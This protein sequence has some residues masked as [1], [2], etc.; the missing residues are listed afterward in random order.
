MRSVIVS[1]LV[2][3]LMGCATPKKPKPQ[4]TKVVNVNKDLDSV[5][6]SEF[7]H[8]ERAPIADLYEALTEQTA[9][10]LSFLESKQWYAKDGAG[11]FY[12]KGNALLTLYGQAQSSDMLS[13]LTENEQK[14][15]STA[16]EGHGLHCTS[17]LNPKEALEAYNAAINLC[18]TQRLYGRR[19]G[20]QRMLKD[21][22][23]YLVD[24]SAAD[25]TWHS[26]LPLHDD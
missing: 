6:A 7:A 5:L 11:V 25:D 17:M 2:L 21:K 23:G 19:A 10:V 9:E 13:K 24:Q 16:L 1:G 12:K 14:Q 8:T 20:V 15:L 4:P 26:V 22:E 18:P 3:A